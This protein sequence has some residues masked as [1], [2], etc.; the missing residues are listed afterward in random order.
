MPELIPLSNDFSFWQFANLDTGL[1]AAA[2]ILGII[3]LSLYHR[4]RRDRQQFVSALN[5]MSQGLCMF[6][7]SGRLILCNDRYI[8]MYGMSP[9][10]IKP[11]CSLQDILQ[12]RKETGSFT[13]DPVQYFTDV[14]NQLANATQTTKVMQLPDG[15][16][17]ALTER[18]MSDGG[19]VVTHND[20]T[21]QSRL[22]LQEAALQINEKRRSDVESAINMFR[23]QVL[24]VL[25]AV[26]D[27]AIT[28]KSTA[29]A[30]LGISSQT[31][32]HVAGAVSSSKEASANVT[33]AASATD[34]L[35]GS[36]TEISRQ[37]I[38]T[39]AIVQ[40][41]AR[42][43]QTASQEIM[44]LADSAQQ[45]GDIVKL[46]QSVAGQTN[47]LALN[48]TIEAA[49]AGEFGR[50][51][52]VVASEVKSL[53]VQ[54]AKATQAIAKQIL[55]VQGAT[56]DTVEVIRHIAQR[57]HEVEHRTTAV[58]AAVEEQNSATVEIAH[59]VTSAAKGTNQAVVVLDAAIN[60]TAETRNAAQ[61]VLGTAEE[62]E[63]AVSDLRSKVE[64]FLKQVAA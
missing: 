46:I 18:V 42:E 11:G 48:A 41:T 22:E 38:S 10:V 50:G 25:R 61:T 57:M 54:T 34:E 55:A 47:L 37:L 8:E 63:I 36:I 52:G 12:H 31:S 49:R 2:L 40:E 56:N 3:S 26:D 33:S 51:F 45:I 17:V 59:N 19:W 44:R 6:D 24:G 64:S 30:L 1:A 5:N 27:N 28:M 39:T 21:E 7:A 13:G 23:D 62:V 60:A 29:T 16:K 9:A 35:S 53:A 15:R 20:V 43:T 32:L 4:V 14:L 58:A